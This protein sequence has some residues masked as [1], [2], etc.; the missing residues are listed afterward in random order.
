MLSSLHSTGE[1]GEG[2]SYPQ[3]YMAESTG[4]PFFST[5]PPTLSIDYAILEEALAGDYNENNIIDAADYAVWRDAVTAGFSALPNRDPAKN[6]LVDED[7]FT[8]W[9]T[10]FGETLGAGAGAGQAVPR[11][12]SAAAADGRATVVPEPQSWTLLCFGFIILGA[13]GLTRSRKPHP[14][15]PGGLRRAEPLPRTVGNTLR[16][17]PGCDPAAKVTPRNGTEAVSYRLASR[18]RYR[19][20]RRANFG[21]RRCPLDPSPQAFTLVELLVVIAIIGILVAML[22][23][24]IQSAREAARRASCTN[25]LKQIGL[26]T[27]HFHDANKHLP[28]PKALV[29]GTVVTSGPATES[30]GSTFVLLLPYLEESS[31]FATYD[32]NKSIFDSPNEELT[33][34]PVAVFLCPSMQFPRDVPQSPCERLGP[35]SYMISAATNIT[36]YDGAPYN[37]DFDG[38][39]AD[40]R[41]A[42]TGNGSNDSVVVLPYTLGLKHITD[43]TSKTF[44]VGENDY[45]LLG[46]DW[47]TCSGLN[48]SFRGGD[49]TWAN[50]YWVY[51]W[52]HINW[53][54]YDSSGRG[55]YNRSEILSDENSIKTTLY[56]NYRS[57]HPGGA[58]FVYVDGSVHF[59]PET[60]DYPVLRAL[61]T[62]AGG[63]VESSV[64]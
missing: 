23:P 38:A 34:Q 8:F 46:Y 50:G 7:D 30:V 64:N 1:F 28:P 48:G 11:A 51:A 55:F 49:Q 9:R 15:A 40:V 59:V 35:G 16:G 10:H 24:A 60:I 17:V 26:A 47:E 25:N 19:L 18:V 4:F 41:V 54:F 12:P 2:G 44:I 58:Q 21:A 31:L 27:H 61:V 52:G 62:R 32:L 14:A 3:W 63:E 37:I 56:R 45:G 20:A 22:L 42:K 13:C 29:P 33:S 39:F 43:G 5:T 6:G 36:T 53:K 57:D